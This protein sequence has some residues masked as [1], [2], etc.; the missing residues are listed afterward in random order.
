MAGPTEQAQYRCASKGCK[1]PGSHIL[2][3]VDR[4]DPAVPEIDENFGIHVTCAKH[5]QEFYEKHQALED[6]AAEE[7]HKVNKFI[8]GQ[9]VPRTAEDFNLIARQH[10]NAVISGISKYV[11]GAPKQVEAPSRPEIAQRPLTPMEHFTQWQAEKKAKNRVN[12]GSN[13]GKLGRPLNTED[14]GGNK[15][16]WGVEQSVQRSG[17]WA[18]LDEDAK[19]K[20]KIPSEKIDTV[21][22]SEPFVARSV[23][24]SIAT[25]GM[26]SQVGFAGS[27]IVTKYR[28]GEKLPR[29]IMVPTRA[30][31]KNG[32][33]YQVD[34]K[35]HPHESMGTPIGIYENKAVHINQIPAHSVDSEGRNE[36]YWVPDVNRPALHPSGRALT[37]DEVR[38]AT[39]Y[40]HFQEA[41]NRR[42]PQRRRAILD[43]QLDVIGEER[44]L[45]QQTSAPKELPNG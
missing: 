6:V 34:V 41:Y 4:S 7:G 36:Y 8:T 40:S 42:S 23:A 39:N 9:P 19:L 21:S 22:K 13:A 2:Y 10:R 31:I 38:G 27:E 20:Y 24:P 11:L 37:V 26:G 1:N 3:R 12:R 16:V 5:G 18:T 43:R 28:S 32:E 35:Q 45:G 15:Y 14:Q 44:A 30:K 29:P 17:G 33:A 25:R